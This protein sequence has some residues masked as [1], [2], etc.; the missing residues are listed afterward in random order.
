VIAPLLNFLAIVFLSGRK[1]KVRDF[2]H[3]VSAVL[4]TVLFIGPV[5]AKPDEASDAEVGGCHFLGKVAGNS[6]FGKNAGWRSLAKSSAEQKAGKLG[7]THIVF[8][9]YRPVGSFNGE[10][11]G[12]AYS[13]KSG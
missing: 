10:A 9:L 8:T 12:K 3:F 13:C 2:K 11:E 7:A 1:L 5:Y 4:M 6:G